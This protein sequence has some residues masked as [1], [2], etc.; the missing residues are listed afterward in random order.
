MYIIY[1]YILYKVIYIYSYIYMIMNVKGE[2]K[3]S[4]T[5]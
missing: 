5:P 4:V 3:Y 2:I 1:L